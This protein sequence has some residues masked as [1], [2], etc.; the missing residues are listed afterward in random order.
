M[1]FA[2]PQEDEAYKKESKYEEGRGC[3]EQS[4]WRNSLWLLPCDLPEILSVW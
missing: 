3:D 1:S 4:L 2:P